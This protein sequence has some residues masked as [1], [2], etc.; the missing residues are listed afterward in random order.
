VYR[1]YGVGQDGFNVS[2]CQFALHYFFEDNVSFHNFLRNVSECTALNGYFV[3]TCYDGKTVFKKLAKK[4]NGEGVAI[5]RQDR[6]IY[7]IIKKYDQ[8]GFPDDELSVGYKIE[9]FQDSINK[10]FAEYLVNFDYLV[11]MMENYGFKILTSTEA[12]NM[13]LPNGSGLFSELFAYMEEEVRQSRNAKSEYRQA[14]EMND[15]EKWISFM[16]RYFVFRKVHHVD[17]EKIYK[18]FVSRQMLADKEKE[19]SENVIQLVPR[20]EDPMD[21]EKNDTDKKDDAAKPKIRKT[22]KPKIVLDKYSPMD[23]TDLPK[24]ETVKNETTVIPK[25]DTPVV[26]PSPITFGKTITIKKIKK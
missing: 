7:E 1:Q 12:Q 3:G 13:G 16:N 14:F 6:K 26:P 25:V 20:V 18:Q 2:S 19:A 11:R 17:A 8:T 9:V 10:T 15:D 4:R 24:N 23:D 22:T 21:S 5:M